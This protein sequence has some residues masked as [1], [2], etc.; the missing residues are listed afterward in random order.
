MVRYHIHRSGKAV[1]SQRIALTFLMLFIVS[2]ALHR[3]GPVIEPFAAKLLKG[4]E[5]W[6]SYLSL[7]TPVALKLAAAATV[8]AALALLLG[9]I[10]MV[11][12]WR[13][14]YLG[15]GKAFTGVF[16]SMLVLAAPAATL[17]KLVSLPRIHEVSTDVQSPPTFTELA[18]KRRGEANPVAYQASEAAEQAKAYPDI[19]PLA[20]NHPAELAFDTVREVVHGLEWNIVLEQPPEGGKA[21]VIEAA[22]RSPVFGFTDDVVIR[23]TGGAKDS[24]VDVRSSARYGDH[25]M[26]RNAERVR[27]LLTEVKT[28]VARIDRDDRIEKVMKR[29][30]EQAQKA[31]ASGKCTKKKK[32]AGECGDDGS[33]SGSGHTNS[34]EPQEE[35]PADVAQDAERGP[36]GLGAPGEP[37][38]TKKPRRSERSPSLR[39]FWEELIE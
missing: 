5:A 33:A 6:A 20:V 22:L 19:Q 37:K 21:G 25:D 26:G 11:N 10:A 15:A 3:F 2:F 24:R 39:R 29:R 31:A 28:R 13:E 35:A 34:I 32:R 17:P 1:W 9:L 16:F 4:H 23:V 30:E 38:E 8:G 12:I 27:A 36:S 18:A 7:S 14:G